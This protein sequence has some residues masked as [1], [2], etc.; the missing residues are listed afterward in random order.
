M[1]A[2]KFYAVTTDHI[3]DVRINTSPYSLDHPLLPWNL[4]IH[5]EK[6]LTLNHVFLPVRQ[7]YWCL[8][9]MDIIWHK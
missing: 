7:T 1:Q 8:G 6:P 5:L 3:Y 2:E 9:W 4:F